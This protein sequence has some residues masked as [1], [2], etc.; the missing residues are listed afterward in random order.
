MTTWMVRAADSGK[1]KIK[2]PDII[3]GPMPFTPT[4]MT[5]RGQCVDFGSSVAYPEL[6]SG[7]FPKVAN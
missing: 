4:D 7:G 1:N 5:T 3:I 6:V 2:Q